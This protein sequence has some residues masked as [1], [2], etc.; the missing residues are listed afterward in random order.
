MPNLMNPIPQNT[1]P[2]KQSK[3]TTERVIETCSIYVTRSYW[4]FRIKNAIQTAIMPS[5]ALRLRITFSADCAFCD[6]STNIGTL[7]VLYI[8]I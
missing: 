1:F 5:T 7:V 4:T 3:K 2:E 8:Y 6:K